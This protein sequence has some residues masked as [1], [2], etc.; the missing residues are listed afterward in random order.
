M[1][2]IIYS[3]IF[4]SIATVASS[5]TTNITVPKTQ[6][7]VVTKLAATWCPFCGSMAWDTY[8]TMVSDLSSKSLVMVAHRSTSSRLYS[9]T[10][11]KVLN[12]YEPVFYQPY[13]FFNTKLI[14]EGDGTTGADMQKAV[15]NF[16]VAT[17]VAQTGL[18]VKFNPTTRDL[19][20]TAKTEFFKTATGNYF[21]GIYL[22]EKSV[23]EQ[24]SNRGSMADHLNVLRTHFGTSEFGFEVGSGTM[25]SGFFKTI[26]TKTTLAT[27]INSANIIIASI[28]WQKTGE[29]TYSMVNANWTDQVSNVTTSVVE[30]QAL[31][32]GYTISPNIVQEKANLEFSLPKAGKNVL[33]QAFDIKGQVVA[34]IFSGNLPAGKH[35][36]QLNRQQLSSKGLYFVRLQV[37]GQFATRQ[38]VVQ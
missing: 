35:Q 38:A 30:N 24:Q 31:K 27:K 3:L 6:K 18:A 9:A 23:I 7:G 4:L 34:T 33:V 5:Q 22:I 26:S 20:V 29:T 32:A 13:F 37:D 12:A 25:S 19:E 14:G 17:P 8:K 21:T 11:E 10:A 28:L 15:D 16:A 36:F 2:Q 1:K